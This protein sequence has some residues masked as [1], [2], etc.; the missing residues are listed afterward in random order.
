MRL[1]GKGSPKLLLASGSPRR[2][3]LL[4]LLGV[5]FQ[6]VMPDICEDERPDRDGAVQACTLAGR[7][8]LTIARQ[9]PADLVIA[10]DTLVVLAGQALGKPPDAGSAIAML[11]A[12][13]GRE[14]S[15]ISGLAVVCPGSA[16]PD[17]QA[18][19]T[20]VWMRDYGDEEIAHY[21]ARGQPFDKAGAYAIQDYHFHPVQRI[22]GCYANVMGLPLC[23]LFVMLT[24]Q[25]MAPPPSLTGPRRACEQHLGR[26]CGVAGPIIAA[27]DH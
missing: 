7:K 8:A 26:A 3:E 27:I 6:V 23:H 21:V 1:T 18:V 25:G 4:R 13:R 16:V 12:L 20:A 15:V 2:R 14:H 10:A 24:R 11:R 9:S 5:P 17:V 19:E 22:E